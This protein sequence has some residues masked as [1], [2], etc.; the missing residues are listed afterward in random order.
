MRI[1]NCYNQF[2]KGDIVLI[3]R[4]YEEN[5]NVPRTG[6]PFK[7]TNNPMAGSLIVVP[8]VTKKSSCPTLTIK[9]G[10]VGS[11]DGVSLEIGAFCII[12]KRGMRS[13]FSRSIR[14]YF[15]ALATHAIGP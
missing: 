3:A 2:G 1:I 10:N 15:S 4:G 14:S 8:V 5:I 6:S 13:P 12:G 9:G 7:S 11:V